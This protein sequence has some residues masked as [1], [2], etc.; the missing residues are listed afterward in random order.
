MLL[1]TFQE[2][3]ARHGPGGA[4]AAARHSTLERQG[5]LRSQCM[6][7]E[8][9]KIG[10]LIPIAGKQSVHSPFFFPFLESCPTLADDLWLILFMSRITHDGF[11]HRLGELCSGGEFSNRA[12]QPHT[13][14]LHLQRIKILTMTITMTMDTGNQALGVSH[15][16]HQNVSLPGRTLLFIGIA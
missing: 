10:A 6:N 16:H 12:S 7:Y 11:V 8:V 14:S 15:L 4:A 1:G 3:Q 9:S 13:S 5:G 2:N